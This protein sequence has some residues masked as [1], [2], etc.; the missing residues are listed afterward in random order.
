MKRPSLLKIIALT[1]IVSFLIIAAS[2]ALF[3]YFFPK[4][5]LLGIITSEVE[6]SL[7]RKLSIGDL[8]Y[9]LKGISIKN[10]TIYDGLAAD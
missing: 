2:A 10:V 5:K 9:G 6:Q 1:V 3:L 4:E 8:D 7:K